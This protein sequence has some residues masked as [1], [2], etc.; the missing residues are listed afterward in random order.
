MTAKPNGKYQSNQIIMESIKCC[1][2][3]IHMCGEYEIVENTLEN[4][5]K[6]IRMANTHFGESEKVRVQNG[7]WHVVAEQ[8]KSG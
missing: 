5:K 4:I 3:Q 7:G 1:W 8:S 2:W 6:L